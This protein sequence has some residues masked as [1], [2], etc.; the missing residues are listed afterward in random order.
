MAGNFIA[1]QA[2]KPVE[3]KVGDY[4]KSYVDDFIK[5]GDLEK[6]T[7]AK[8]LEDQKKSINDSFNNFKVDSFG[9]SAD[10]TDFVM[11][12]VQSTADYIG[13][14]KSL[15]LSDPI[16][17]QEHTNNANRAWID[18]RNMATT[19]GSTDFI[20]K[21]N[22][23]QQAL[24]DHDVFKPTDGNQQL[25]MIAHQIPLVRRQ[26]NGTNAYYL[27]QNGNAISSD[28]MPPQS[29]GQLVSN[30]TA[31]DDTNLLQSNKSNGNNGFLD[32]QV[33]T[34]AAKM[35]DILNKNTDGNVTNG[36][37][38]FAKDRGN[39]WFN[40][41]FG[42]YN[43]NV[44]NPVMRQYANQ[45]LKKSIDGQNGEDVYNQVKAGIIDLVGS[46]V[47]NKNTIKTDKSALEIQGQKNALVLDSLR[48]AQARKNLYEPDGNLSADAQDFT[49]NNTVLRLNPK[50][51]NDP[52]GV[53]T[54]PAFYNQPGISIKGSYKTGSGY[55]DVLI[56]TYYSE[57]Q[58]NA[59]GGTG[60]PVY[61]LSVPSKNGQDMI[62]IPL[63]TKN[64]RSGLTKALTYLSVTGRAKLIKSAQMVMANNQ[65]KQSGTYIKDNTSNYFVNDKFSE[66][67]G[68]NK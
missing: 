53:K 22:A 27:P 15:A 38:W 23:K 31:P 67:L 36:K 37:E 46:L 52:N 5:R 8:T 25:A 2:L 18:Y 66:A 30:I 34:V 19:F 20:Q 60:I 41:T 63:S 43:A 16:N 1:Y 57:N 61:G 9:T 58:K 65:L 54:L 47:P 32:K 17:A 40:T 11:N 48:I 13:N 62:T 26:A 29:W 56:T 39:V 28:P 59:A 6:A 64:D 4:Y 7:K 21:A 12:Q 49:P 3:L 44:I 35:G 10:M 14:E 33:Y 55:K 51:R 42:A 24:A 68:T 50:D 45:V